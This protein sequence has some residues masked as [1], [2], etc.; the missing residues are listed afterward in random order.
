MDSDSK[1]RQ[2]VTTVCR[3]RQAAFSGTVRETYKKTSN[4]TA[5]DGVMP[6]QEPVESIYKK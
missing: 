1:T 5:E 4:A 3:L 6:Q 2:T